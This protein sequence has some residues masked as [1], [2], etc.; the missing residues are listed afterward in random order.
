MSVQ[1]AYPHIEKPNS[2][3]AHL[4]R[5]P[6]VRVAQIVMDYLAYGWSAD[7]L[8][9][10]H[11]Y[12]QLAEAHA[13]MAYY[14]D[15]QEEIEAGIRAEMEQVEEARMALAPSPFFVRMRERDPVMAVRFYMDSRRLASAKAPWTTTSSPNAAGTIS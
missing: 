3:P 14:Y 10:Q 8:C 12:L 7:E 9:R 11:P 2:E 15:H 5:L 1:L 6:R 13:A 4:Q